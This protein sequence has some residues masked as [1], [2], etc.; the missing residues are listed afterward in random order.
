MQHRPDYSLYH[1]HELEAALADIDESENPEE[2]RIIREHIEKG[3]YTYPVEP[4]MVGVRFVNAI[5]KWFLVSVL[6]LLLLA[7]LIAL[8]MGDIGALVPIAVHG[9]LLF[10]IYVNHKYTRAV[11]KILCALMMI[12]GLSGVIST[13]F[14][15]DWL[16]LV[17]GVLIFGGGLT[18]FVLSNRFVELVRA[19]PDK[20]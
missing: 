12:A 11:I 14:V 2:A 3:G 13:F 9:G 19:S 18:I 17:S 1:L 4:K 8:V 20:A 7:N 15:M 5:Y 16:R 10:M 6:A